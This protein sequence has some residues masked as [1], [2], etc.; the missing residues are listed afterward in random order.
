[1]SV[2]YLLSKDGENI[3]ALDCTTNVSR[4]RSNSI[5]TNSVMSGA[6]ASDTYTIGNQTISFTGLVTYNKTANSATDSPDPLEFQT[7]L[8]DLVRSYTRFDLFGNDL[9]PTLKDCVLTEESYT[10]DTFE[11]TIRVS[12]SVTEVFVT[13]PADR[14]SLTVT[15]SVTTEGQLADEKDGGSGSK[16]VVPASTL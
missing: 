2:V 15:P 9:I 12:L 11:D 7:L 8:N 3:I 13:D 5:T 1:M 14:T 10:Q 4:T 6:N 16:S